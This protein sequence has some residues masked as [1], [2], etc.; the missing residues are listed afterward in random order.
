[1]ILDNP[2]TPLLFY[3]HQNFSILT[4]M[5]HEPNATINHP[6][7]ATSRDLSKGTILWNHRKIDNITIIYHH[8]HAIE[9]INH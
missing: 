6:L 4:T 9:H 3:Q 1:M 8:N 7:Q 2:P 5:N